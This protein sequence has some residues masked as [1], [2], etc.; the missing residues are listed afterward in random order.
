MGYT[1]KAAL[2]ADRDKLPNTG[3]DS[4]WVL[5]FSSIFVKANTKMVEEETH[6]L[7]AL[8]LIFN[9]RSKKAGLTPLYAI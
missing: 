4:E 8:Y 9:N 2:K 7:F 1:L 5:E 3:V 6:N